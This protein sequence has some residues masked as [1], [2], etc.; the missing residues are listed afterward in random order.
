M[1][2]EQRSKAY[3]VLGHALGLPGL[4]RRA[5]RAADTDLDAIACCRSGSMQ[6]NPE[7]FLM[8]RLPREKK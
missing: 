2:C 6:P 7:F 8:G 3:L 5:L 1:S 4:D